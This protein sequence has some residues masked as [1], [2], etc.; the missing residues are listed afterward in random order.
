MATTMASRAMM[1]V[2]S[3]SRTAEVQPSATMGLKS[4]STMFYGSSL[5]L[6][7]PSHM[8]GVAGVVGRSDGAVVGTAIASAASKL[9]KDKP[10][11]SKAEQQQ[12]VSIVP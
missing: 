9:V 4:S 1:G 5:K 7:G 2:A 6:G 12:L 10:K 8:S 11:S 3:P